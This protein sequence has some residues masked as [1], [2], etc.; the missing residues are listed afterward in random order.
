MRLETVISNSVMT[1]SLVG[2]LSMTDSGA[3]WD[4]MATWL[5]TS[6]SGMT[7]PTERA[8][9]GKMEMSF[10]VAMMKGKDE[11]KSRTALSTRKS[12]Q[13]GSVIIR[14]PPGILCRA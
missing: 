9:K 6:S 3:W 11:G 4:S 7:K 13:A 14:I 5:I 8:T 2:K 10:M 12:T 1:W